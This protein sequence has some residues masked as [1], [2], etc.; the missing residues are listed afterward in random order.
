MSTPRSNAIYHPHLTLPCSTSSVPKL[1]ANPIPFSFP[2]ASSSPAPS[3]SIRSILLSSTPSFLNGEG[4]I[5]SSMPTLCAVARFQYGPLPSAM[6][7]SC[8]PSCTTLPLASTTI[9][10]ARRTV[11]RRWAMAM[12]VRPVAEAARSRAAWT[13][14]S[15]RG[16][17]EEV[18]SSRMRRGG[19]RTKARA[20]ERRWRWPVESLSPEGPT[21]VWRPWGVLVGGLECRRGKGKGG[22]AYIWQ[23]RDELVRKGLATRL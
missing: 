6:R 20:R 5:P 8:V 19:E 3:D 13:M 15:E 10:S 21:F 4:P 7:P 2:S 16:S 12:V 11:E 23:P 9:L 1:L 14:C 17:R 18:A 22:G